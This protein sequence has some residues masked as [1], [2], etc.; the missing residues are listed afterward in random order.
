MPLLA[1]AAIVC[2]IIAPL[3]CVIRS[4]MLF[5]AKKPLKALA[6]VAAAFASYLAFSAASL[7]LMG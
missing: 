2:A 5:E 3:V 1:V 7:A 6:T 4:T